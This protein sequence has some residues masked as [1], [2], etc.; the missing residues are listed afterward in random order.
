MKKENF[1]TNDIEFASFLL[2]QKVSY[3][4]TKEISPGRS[5]FVFKDS[6]LCK[7]LRSE[8]IADGKAPALSLFN[9][10]KFLLGEMKSGNR[11]GEGYG[12]NS[13]W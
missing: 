8:F 12:R 1:I 6:D 5:I 3:I 7:R 13:N 9:K 4:E 11:N 2:T 10:R